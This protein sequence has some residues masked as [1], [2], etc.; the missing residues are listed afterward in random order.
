M[1]IV[2]KIYGKFNIE[3]PVLLALIDSEALQRLK[4][5]SQFGVPN[6]YLHEANG[7]SRYEHSLGV[8]CLL[9]K[10]KA[11]QEEQLAGLLHDVSHLAFS[12]VVDYVFL[13]N[14]GDETY[15]DLRH[16]E[17]ILSPKISKIL[18]NYGYEPKKISDLNSFTLLDREI[19]SLCADRIDYCLREL[20]IEESRKLSNCLTVVENKIVFNNKQSA[21]QF[22]ND[23]LNLQTKWWG[24]Q[25]NYTCYL[26]F[27]HMLKIALEKRIIHESDLLKTES[28]IWKKIV[29]AKNKK[30]EN[31]LNILRSNKFDRVSFTNEKS[32][33]KFRYVDPEFLDGKTIKTLSKVDKDFADLVAKSKLENAKGL[34]IPDMTKI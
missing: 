12:H 11:S 7:F 18:L 22:A 16:Q 13:E 1:K 10:L 27:S 25:H 14:A 20:P 28:L 8:F 34:Y 4:D 17:E 3:E 33:K 24:S 19:P 6:D 2:D 21:T 29:K 15:Q 26:L 5:I 9:R 30:I 32:I 23:F 31:I